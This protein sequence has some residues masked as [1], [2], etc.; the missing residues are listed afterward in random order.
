VDTPNVAAG[1]GAQNLVVGNG[2]HT[3]VRGNL[4]VG[5]TVGNDN[6]N[7]VHGT[8]DP[9][10][11]FAPTLSLFS[12]F[13]NNNKVRSEGNTNITSITQTNVKRM[14]AATAYRVELL[15]GSLTAARKRG[16]QQAISEG[17]VDLVIGTHALIQE[18][19]QFHKL[20]LV[21][22]DE[23]HRFGVLQ[24]AELIKRGYN[25]DTLVMT[26][27]PI[28]RSLAMTVYGDLDLSIIDEMPPGR[29]P[30]VTKV[31]SEDARNKIYHFLDGVIRKGRQVYIVYRW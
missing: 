17:E 26:A 10:N 7:I 14:L 12:V 19:V 25:P 31:R 3:D 9:N 5:L 29:K 16:L 22:I 30:V 27:T 6:E 8:P 11:V 20:G 18:A 24:R 28:P 15:T 2:N 13:G 21:V 1:L 4:V 23:Q